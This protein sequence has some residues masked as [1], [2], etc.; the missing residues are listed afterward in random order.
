MQRRKHDAVALRVAQGRFGEEGV[1]RSQF[2]A[3]ASLPAGDE[4]AG[5][6]RSPVPGERVRA[7]ARGLECRGRGVQAA[8]CEIAIQ[9]EQHL[10]LPQGCT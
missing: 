5:S 7:D 2:T 4:R 8:T 3:D 6:G 1:Q 9:V 10:A